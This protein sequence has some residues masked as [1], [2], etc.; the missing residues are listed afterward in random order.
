M[1]IE[2][3]L[4]KKFANIPGDVFK[5]IMF[6]YLNN[7]VLDILLNKPFEILQ[8]AVIIENSTRKI[9][10]RNYIMELS[11]Y[12]LINFILYKR[13][14]LKNIRSYIKRAEINLV[15]MEEALISKVF[16]FNNG[17]THKFYYIVDVKEDS[18]QC[19]ELEDALELWEIKTFRRSKYCDLTILDRLYSD[20]TKAVY[21]KSNELKRA[22][23]LG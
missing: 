15:K 23:M 20:I 5:N 4:K 17:F 7:N 21:I 12:E 19:I 18:L 6:R 2:I 14:G 22:I 11:R 16:N 1:S 3:E 9:N 10:N 8:N 13:G